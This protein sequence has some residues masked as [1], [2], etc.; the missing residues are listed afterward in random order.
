[1]VR[2]F[3]I[4][5]APRM[6]RMAASVSHSAVLVAGPHDIGLDVGLTNEAGIP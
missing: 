6:A 5:R 4:A 3:R 2:F 1:M